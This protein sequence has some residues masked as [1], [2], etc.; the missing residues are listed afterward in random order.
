MSS[1]IRRATA[2]RRTLAADGV[3]MV[4]EP[5]AGDRLEDNV[6]PVG[7]T[8]YGGSTF[9]CTP[10]ALAQGGRHTLG[11]QAG[12]AALTEVLNAAGFS[13]VRVAAETPFNLVLEARV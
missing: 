3:L 10:S 6:G 4:V 5:R 8:Y 2:A 12:P 9:L 7:R 11:A 1:N 13:R